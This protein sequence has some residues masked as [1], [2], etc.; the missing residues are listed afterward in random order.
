MS[1][2]KNTAGLVVSAMKKKGF[3]IKDG[4]EIKINK[5]IP[6]GYGMGSS[7]AS[8]SACAVGINKLFNLKLTD[9]E[10]VELR[11]NW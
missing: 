11:W 5:N 1:P 6:A 2:S 3:K 8:A 7:A 9:A 10:L 4:I